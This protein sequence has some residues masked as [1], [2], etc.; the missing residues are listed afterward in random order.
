MA[1]QKLLYRL[2]YPDTGEGHRGVIQLALTEDQVAV[3]ARSIGKP[4]ARLQSIEL[5]E[6]DGDGDQAS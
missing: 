6:G 3:M 2:A 4:G 5:V 1:E